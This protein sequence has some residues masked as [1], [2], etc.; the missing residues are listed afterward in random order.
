MRTKSILAMLM[1]TAATLT[2]NYQ[3]AE[4]A[5]VNVNING[6]LPAPPGVYVQVDA[7]RPYYVQNDRRVYMERRPDKHRKHFK[8]KKHHDNGVK[9]GHYK[10]EGRGEHEGGEHGGGR[11]H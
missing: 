5:N 11:G 7:G 8:E 2:L 1:L 10:D 9:N 6:Y 3:P 4:A